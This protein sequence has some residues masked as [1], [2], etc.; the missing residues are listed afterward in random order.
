MDANLKSTLSDRL[1]VMP[2][3]VINTVIVG[4]LATVEQILQGFVIDRDIAIIRFKSSSGATI[5]VTDSSYKSNAPQWFI[6]AMGIKDIAKSTEVEVGGFSYGTIEVVATPKFYI[7]EIYKDLLTACGLFIIFIVANV[8][9]VWY[10][11]R[12]GLLPAL[13][14]IENGA[15]AISEGN[16]IFIKENSAKE[17]QTTFK[18]FNTMVLAIKKDRE[19]LENQALQIESITNTMLEALYVTDISGRI[20]SVN[21]YATKLLGYAKEELLGKSAHDLFHTDSANKTPISKCNIYQV[22]QKKSEY[23]GEDKF[24]DK[25]GKEFFVEVAAKV[26]IENDRVI[27][28]VVTFRDISEQKKYR[29][30]LLKLL[31]SSPIAVRIA[32]ENGKKVVFAN[33]AYSSLIKLEQ[34]NVIG[35]NPKNYYANRE[36]YDAIVEQI[37]HNEP[38]HNKLVQLNVENKIRWALASYMSMEFEGEESVLGWF[39]DITDQESQKMELQF[40]KEK[41]EIA[42]R[43]KSEFLANMSHEIRT[44]L[45]GVLGLTELVLKTN[46]DAQQRD[47]LEKAKTSSKALLYVIND[48]LDYS[49][50]EAGKLELEHRLFELESV[51]K[52]I[53]NLFEYQANKKGLSLNISSYN[54]LT[55]VGDALR[56]TQILT[57]IV[58]NAIKF[59]EKGSINIKIE[60]MHEDEHYKK[61]KFSIKDSGVGMSKA[62]QEN[63]FRAFTQADSSITRQYGGTGLGLS[64]SKR[65]VQMMSGEIWVESKEGVGSEFIFSAT[66]ANVDEKEERVIIEVESAKLNTD[67]IKGAKILLVEDNKI[68]QTVAI[69]MLENLAITADI[70][71]N[72]R[73]AVDRIEEG[74][75]YDLVLMDLQMPIMDGFEASKQIKKINENIPIIALSA[76][77]MQEDIIKTSEAKMSAH[78]AKPINEDELIRTLLQF[79]KPKESNKQVFKEE[80]K[81]FPHAVSEFYGVNLEELK[82]RI[83]DKPKTIIKLLSS[84]CEEFGDIEQILDISK[85]ETDEFNHALHSLKGVSG[86]ISLKDIYKLSKEIYETNDLQ[87]KKE[88]APKLIELLKETVKNLTLQLSQEANEVTHKEYKKEE[89]LKYLQG[90]QKDIK[91]FRAITGE[92][93]ALLEEMLFWHVEVEIIKELSSSLLGYKYKEADKMFSDIYALLAD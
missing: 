23:I 36:E 87:V 6:N 14:A 72:G 57:N 37:S 1:K 21:K 26:L 15:D 79:I 88:N 74:R 71:N 52:N 92:R 59:T 17:L 27:G 13:K 80:E 69:G 86:N 10:V 65:L 75:E 32:Q 47:Y 18:A 81:A 38:I 12:K 78:L 9:F 68:N 24:Y 76:A 64:I 91:H 82:N 28:S 5:E 51:M 40:Q 70:A 56:L 85:I 46:L 89:I 2:S 35:Q 25:H 4:D 22:I 77:V 63:L 50:I 66:F 7:D 48:V 42:N 45:N 53:V 61:L 34:E 84:F 90:I 55:L 3:T 29:D 93:V 8:F 49:K 73:E 20:I 54:K 44:P 19:L 33:R 58:G 11:L 16:F 67:S 83:G 31:E 30:T 60:L 39:Y 62:H 41:A 43:A